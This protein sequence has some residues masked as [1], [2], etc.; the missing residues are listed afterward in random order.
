MNSLSPC[1]LNNCYLLGDYNIILF[2][3]EVHSPT[4]EFIDL[5]FN[6]FIDSVFV[7]I[8]NNL[9]RISKTIVVDVIYRSPGTDV[10]Q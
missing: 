7:E 1:L 3:Y 6:E 4:A 9:F 2:N 10:S 8:P 5:I